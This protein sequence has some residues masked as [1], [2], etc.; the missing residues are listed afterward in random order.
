MGTI[1]DKNTLRVMLLEILSK[2]KALLKDIL[3][4]LLKHDPQFL[5]D[6]TSTSQPM[7]VSEPSVVY[8]IK[9]NKGQNTDTEG[10]GDEE[11]HLLIDKHFKQYEAVFKALA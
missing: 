10:I 11:L 7:F 4:D 2:D 8:N 6:F 1:V 9:E 3:Q 5:E